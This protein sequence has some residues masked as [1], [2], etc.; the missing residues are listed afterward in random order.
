MSL[1]PHDEVVRINRRPGEITFRVRRED[2][3]LESVTLLRPVW[4]QIKEIGFVVQEVAL[5]DPD[6]NIIAEI[7]KRAPEV[8]LPQG[9]RQLRIM[10][11][12]DAKISIIFANEK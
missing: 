8:P 4:T 11:H 1:K 9:L 5:S 10:D 7:M 12:E 6:P 3:S 2:K